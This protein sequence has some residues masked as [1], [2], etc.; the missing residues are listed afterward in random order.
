MY[1]ITLY[2]Y[3]SFALRMLDNGGISLS[4]IIFLF[5]ASSTLNNSQSLAVKRC[6][7]ILQCST[8][9][10]RITHRLQSAHALMQERSQPEEREGAMN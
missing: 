7:V 1:E 5:I 8:C 6:A 10:Y 4:A 2:H 9:A 3:K